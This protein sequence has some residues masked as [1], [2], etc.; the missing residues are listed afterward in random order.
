MIIVCP[1]CSKNF[2]VREDQIPDKGRLLQCSN[3]KHEWFYTKNTI[4]VDDKIDEQLKGLRKN[5]L[6]FTCA[7][8]L[9]KLLCCLIKFSCCNKQLGNNLIYLLPQASATLDTFSN[10]PTLSAITSSDASC[11]TV[12]TIELP[13][14]VL[15]KSNFSNMIFKFITENF[16]NI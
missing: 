16:K 9:S 1:S 6:S 7:K 2:N 12:Y 10:K 14:V 15:S 8:T 13:I 11:S 3:C 4:P 5:L